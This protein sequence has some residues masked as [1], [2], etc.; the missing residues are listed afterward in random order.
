MLVE[1]LQSQIYTIEQTIR[2]RMIQ[3]FKKIRANDRQQIQQLQVD[4]EDL[5]QSS[6]TNQGLFTQH[7]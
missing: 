3:D 2:N 7:D 4:L 6:Q 1:N 5:H